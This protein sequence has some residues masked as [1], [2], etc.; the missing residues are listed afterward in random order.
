MKRLENI[1]EST[2]TADSP[3]LQ[4]YGIVKRK[5]KDKVFSPEDIEKIS[6]GIVQRLRSR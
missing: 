3:A 5:K 4:D 2:T 6:A 1:L